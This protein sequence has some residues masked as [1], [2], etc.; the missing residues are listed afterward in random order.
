MQNT[1]TKYKIQCFKRDIDKNYVV[2]KR[3]PTLSNSVYFSLRHVS[4]IRR[5]NTTKILL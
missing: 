4:S 2:V 3:F 1:F 5:D